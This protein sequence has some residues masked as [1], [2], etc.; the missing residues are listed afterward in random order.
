[1]T[2]CIDIMVA[3]HHAQQLHAARVVA[4][5]LTSHGI[6]HR[7][8]ADSAQTQADIVVTWGWHCA[9]RLQRPGRHILVMELAYLGD[10][11]RWL[12]LGWDGLNGR[13]RFAAPDDGGARWRR[14]F[15]HLMHPWRATRGGYALLMGQV[16]SDMAVRHLDH[17][18][19]LHDTACA[20]RFRGHEVRYRHHPL[21]PEFE[22][23]ARRIEGD[24]ADAFA[25]AVFAVTCNSNAG[26]DAVLAGV[27]A[28]TLDAGA[29][30]HAVA[31]HDLD[32]PVVTPD[33]QPWAQRMAWT[34]WQP[35]E[36]AAGEAWPH[37]LAAL[38]DGRGF[39]PCAFPAP[40]VV[41]PEAVA[42]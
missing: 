29:M 6:A 11:R 7:I 17:R 28:V 26:V 38:E 4:E 13:A 18:R 2:D 34:Q 33:R 21:A 39:T 30:A 37:L 20:L 12:S 35:D 23:P 9:R 24:I 3:P 40:R 36:I 32:H 8:I 42:A 15:A 19:W 16:P 41:A 10:R 25:G 1:M 22:N 5:G 31:S 27:P 14:Y